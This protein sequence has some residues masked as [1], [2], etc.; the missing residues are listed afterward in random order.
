MGVLR[1]TPMLLRQAERFLEEYMDTP[2]DVSDSKVLYGTHHKEL[3]KDSRPETIQFKTKA[4]TATTGLLLS[5]PLFMFPKPKYIS[6][7]AF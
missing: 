2:V 6:V 3:P 1:E 7:S 4:Y 5:V